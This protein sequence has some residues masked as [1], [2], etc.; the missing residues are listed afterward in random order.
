MNTLKPIELKCKV[1]KGYVGYSEVIS[2][3]YPGA[4]AGLNHYKVDGKTYVG[5]VIFDGI[6]SRRYK[7]Y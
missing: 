5:T 3:E 7:S 6:G 1:T 2:F 4:D